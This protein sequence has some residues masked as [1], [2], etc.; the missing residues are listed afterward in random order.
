MTPD[1]RPDYEATL[2]G[3]RLSLDQAALDAAWSSGEVMSM[4]QAVAYALKINH[5]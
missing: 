4:E 5:E 2:A 3:I 1:E